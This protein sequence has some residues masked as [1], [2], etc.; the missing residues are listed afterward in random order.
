MLGTWCLVHSC[1]QS[2]EV[3]VIMPT[4]EVSRLGSERGAQL[5]SHTTPQGQS[6]GSNSIYQT[7]FFF[8]TLCQMKRGQVDFSTWGVGPGAPDA[9]RPT[10]TPGIWHAALCS[11]SASPPSP[12]LG[13]SHRLRHPI[14]SPEPVPCPSSRPSSSLQPGPWQPL[15]SQ[16]HTWDLSVAGVSMAQASTPPALQNTVSPTFRSSQHFR[17]H[18]S[19]ALIR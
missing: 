13:L 11:H 18:S 1:Q 12:A 14:C 3:G 4:F 9:P 8:K 15:R 7:P 19:G 5:P 17:G 6:G 16:P 10:G 2:S